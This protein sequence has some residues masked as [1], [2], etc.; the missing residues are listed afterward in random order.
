MLPISAIRQTL[1]LAV[2]TVVA[3]G[4]PL[5]L[6][7]PDDIGFVNLCPYGEYAEWVVGDRNAIKEG[8]SHVNRI[9]PTNRTVESVQEHGLA[10]LTRDRIPVAYG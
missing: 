5:C 1:G 9:L 10:V 4:R 3:I 6:S 7:V 8:V 2:R